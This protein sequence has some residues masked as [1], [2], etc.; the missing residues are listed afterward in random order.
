MYVIINNTIIQA[1]FKK[2][3]SNI[4]NSISN[5]QTFTNKDTLIDHSRQYKSKKKTFEKL[6][7]KSCLRPFKV[8]INITIC[9]GYEQ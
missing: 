3:N 6:E 2:K 8:K 5:F 7:V 1:L 9:S 4:F